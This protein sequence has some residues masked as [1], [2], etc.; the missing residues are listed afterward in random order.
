MNTNNWWKN[1]TR[2]IQ[3]NLQIK[4]T[5]KIKPYKLAEQIKELGANTLV[6]NVGGIYAW[7]ESKIK[8]H[9]NNPYLPEDTD[10]LKKVIEACHKKNIKFI[11][12]LD[13][14]K[15]HDYIYAN[16]PEWFV[17]DENGEP[18]IIGAKRPG[19]WSGH[20]MSTCINSGYRN[21]E[22]AIPV[23][24]E[25]IDNYN[26]DGIFYNAPHFVP[27][28]CEKCQSKYRDLYSEKLPLNPEDYHKDWRLECFNDNI[29]NLFGFI[30]KKNENLPVILYYGL[31]EH[32]L[33]ERLDITDLIC[34][35]SQNVLS[36]GHQDIPKLWKPSLNTK[37]GRKISQ[38]ELPVGIIHSCPG[39]DWRHTGL[40]P[41]EYIF[42]LS[43]I[44]AN[45]GQI[46]HSLTG[47][48][49]TI[50][51][52]R[53]LKTV[54]KNNNMIKKV[55]E[56]MKDAENLADVGLLWNRDSAAEGWADALINRQIPFDLILPEKMDIN[57][58]EKFKVIIIPDNTNFSSSLIT[59]LCDF[60]K[61][62]KNIIIEGIMPS[63]APQLLNLLGIKEKMATSEY[64]TASYMRFKKESA[65]INN[66]FEETELIPFRG[67]VSYCKSKEGTETLTTLVP[68]FS[69]LESV[70]APPERASLPVSHTDI[71]LTILNKFNKGQVVYF[72]FS[73]SNLINK[74]K[75]N[76]HYQLILNTIDMLV[77]NNR[78][79]KVDQE[80]QGLHLTAFQKDN[81][82]LI[83]NLV[84]GI[85][86]RP[87]TENIFVHDIDLSLS[88]EKDQTIK[89]VKGLIENRSYKFKKNKDTINIKIPELKIWESLLIKTK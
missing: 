86:T 2:I 8:Y 31:Y 34:T 65:E 51:D 52:K 19:K 45:G 89:E 54:K 10:L 53:I 77:N 72:P 43:L 48:P 76:E 1:P 87:L 41:S 79:I 5:D 64:L 84:N 21:D 29:N 88:L 14:S 30:K 70:G 69:P 13:F 66:G 18:K 33:S 85:G 56:H 9:F 39:M 17:R 57:E 23:L 78:K 61:K 40:P 62:G 22:V 67:K 32:N 75:L 80:I 42:W 74:F 44:P 28:N 60:V 35:E 50:T 7:Y 81:N 38:N 6:Y 37:L 55:E 3:T 16:K 27:C 73:L 71:P 49:D 15:A 83:I 46:W 12:R 63:D 68:P 4:D 59:K 58:L 11:G 24:E 36:R 26:I 47:I 25:V 20:L 82:D